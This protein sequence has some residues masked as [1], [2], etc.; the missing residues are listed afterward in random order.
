MLH[1][2]S[3]RPDA[4]LKPFTCLHT[5]ILQTSLLHLVAQITK[6]NQLKLPNCMYLH[7][8]VGATCDT[9]WCRVLELSYQV[10]AWCTNAEKLGTKKMYFQSCNVLYYSVPS[11][12]EHHFLSLTVALWTGT[13]GKGGSVDWEPGDNRSFP[14]T[15]ADPK[16]ATAFADKSW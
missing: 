10:P 3:D 7:T 16:T 5:C 9:Y 2:P 11:F 6:L 12:P 13:Q 1:I 4:M 8:Q 15:F 14:S